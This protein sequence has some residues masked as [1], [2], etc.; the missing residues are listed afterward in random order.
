MKRFL[1][2][3]SLL[4]LVANSATAYSI[5][6]ADFQP[7]PMTV[8]Q[9][10]PVDQPI[11]VDGVL[12]PSWEHAA[13]FDNFA[14]FSP[15]QFEPAKVPTEGY[16]THDDQHLYIAFVCHD[17]DIRNLRAS[18]TDRDNIFEDDFVGVV[19]DTYQDQQR[20]YEFFANPHGIQGD[21]MWLANRSNDDN[22][23]WYASGGEDTSFDS[24]WKSEGRI[25]EDKWVVEMQ[26]PYASLRFPNNSKQDWGVHFVRTYPRENRYQ[27]SWMPISHDNNSFMGQAG[28]VHLEFD[29][30]A[31][32]SRSLEF[33][34][35]YVATQEGHLT[36]DDETPGH[37]DWDNE[38]VDSRY[39]FNLKYS[40]SS[41]NILDFTYKP[42]FSQIESD[43]GR[44]DAKSTFAFF[45][46]ERRPFFVEGS[47][48]FRVDQGA[49][50]LILDSPANLI[51]TRS[52]NDPLVAG[53]VTGKSG[54]LS[55]GVISAQDDES[56]ILI[57]L[58]DGTVWIPTEEES[59][60]NIFRAKYD[61]ADG[62][63][64][65]VAATNRQFNGDGSN[66]ATAVD[67]SVRLSEKYTFIGVAA[68]T[69]TDEPNDSLYSAM[70]PDTEFKVGNKTIT[71]DFDGQKFYGQI[72]KARLMRQARHW[73]Y[74]LG[75]QDYSPGVRAEN[76]SIFGNDGRVLE[77]WSGYNF[78]YDDH[79]LFSVIHPQVSLWRKYD[80]EGDVKDTGIRPQ[81]VIQFQRQTALN[82]SAFVFNRE[83]FRG[84]HFDD[85]RN[86]WGYLG[87]NMFEKVSGGV[88]LLYGDT[89]NRRGIEGDP[90]NPFELVPNMDFNFNITLR[91]VDQIE[92]GF[93]YESTRLWTNNDELI[94]KQELFRN[95]F[96]YQFSRRLH[97]RMIAE[98]VKSDYYSSALGARVN[99]RT[100]TF[101]PLMSYKLNP[102]TVFYVGANLGGEED[103]YLN[104]D[105]LTRTD[106]TIFLKFQYLWNVM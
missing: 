78:R 3:F 55:Y 90:H 31:F 8:L 102:F 95:T 87:T 5:D 45:Y 98:M 49:R 42:D 11:L 36:P 80:Y 50:G 32:S 18:V 23:L 21:M 71:A 69:Y 41:N 66:T 22:A 15:A 105:G 103:P 4:C 64:V 106:Q 25:Y 13:R 51:Y 17:P 30:G 40:I 96:A 88:F 44:L 29:D 10:N 7:N 85:A 61:V 48:I 62:S 104:Y 58:T 56:S 46:Q 82:I 43:G 14:E 1:L 76:S 86:I 67:A 38:K 101:E 59:W 89:I 93:E 73:N 60:S 81:V 57:P 84:K 20:A 72:F 77:A 47:D 34:P 75:Y 91:P 97:V 94:V 79:P 28:Q 26:I 74:S 27:F 70:I 54:K 92:N 100:F 68:L 99:S 6:P 63:Y 53:K 65:G 52:I 37:G 39:G 16:I 9:L 35:Y 2:V 24:V 12:E 19:I 33:M 83:K